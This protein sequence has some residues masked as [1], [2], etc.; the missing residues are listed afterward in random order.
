MRRTQGRKA[1]KEENVEERPELRHRITKAYRHSLRA[2]PRK[3]TQCGQT[4]EGVC[5]FVCLFSCFRNWALTRKDLWL[6]IIL[7]SFIHLFAFQYSYLT[8]LLEY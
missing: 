1:N 2:L 4:S 3:N 5:L 6:Q 7:H 8:L